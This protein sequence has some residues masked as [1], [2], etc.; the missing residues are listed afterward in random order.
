ML[1][2]GEVIAG[3][4]QF[5]GV[6]RRWS[7]IVTITSSEHHSHT[8][9]RLTARDR[10]TERHCADTTGTVPTPWAGHF[11]CLNVH[12]EIQKKVVR[13]VFLT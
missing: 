8:R 2:D 12:S 1:D 7:L 3:V 10:H 13:F 4:G 6:G 9:V 11:Q 5:V